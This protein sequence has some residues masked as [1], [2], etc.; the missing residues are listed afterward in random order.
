MKM[1]CEKIGL[2]SIN[3]NE[4][5]KGYTVFYGRERVYDEETACYTL[6]M[7]DWSAPH[8]HRPLSSSNFVVLRKNLGHKNTGMQMKEDSPS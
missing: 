5:T 1:S 6:I 2:S 4:E 3:H 8:H 7:F